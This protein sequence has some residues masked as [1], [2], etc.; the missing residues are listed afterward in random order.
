L[1]KIYS[2]F[3]KSWSNLTNKLKRIT[4]HSMDCFFGLLVL[5]FLKKTFGKANNCENQFKFFI[6]QLKSFW[7]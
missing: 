3:L 6:C 1:G 4:L 7:G 2:I 5:E